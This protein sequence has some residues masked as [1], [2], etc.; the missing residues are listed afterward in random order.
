[1]V[2]KDSDVLGHSDLFQAHIA[3]LNQRRRYEKVRIL[4]DYLDLLDQKPA[5]DIYFLDLHKIVE[6]LGEPPQLPTEVLER[7]EERTLSPDTNTVENLVERLERAVLLSKNLLDSEKAFAT[8][9]RAQK[10]L[11]TDQIDRRFTPFQNPS[12]LEAVRRT[13]DELIVWIEDELPKGSNG[14]E[15]DN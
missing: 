3:L 10:S 6:T 11:S 15:Q 7:E 12:K 8:K 14:Q 9:L 13:R 1:A 5:S 2:T 4:Q